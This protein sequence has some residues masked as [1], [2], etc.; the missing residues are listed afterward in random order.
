MAPVILS[1][2]AGLMFYATHFPECCWPGKFDYAGSHSIWHMFII[3]AIRFNWRA[4]Q[5]MQVRSETETC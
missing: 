1:Y 4:V 2:I 5:I 3:L